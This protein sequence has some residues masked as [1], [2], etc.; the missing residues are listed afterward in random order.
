M[1]RRNNCI[2]WKLFISSEIDSNIN[3]LWNR[4]SIYTRGYDFW[5]SKV[6]GGGESR[7]AYACRLT[8]DPLKILFEI[9]EHVTQF[10][11]NPLLVRF[12]F[13]LI[14]VDQKW[15]FEQ[16][17]LVIINFEENFGW[18]KSESACI[19]FMWLPPSHTGPKVGPPRNIDWLFTRKFLTVHNQNGSSLKMG[20]LFRIGRSFCPGLIQD[21]LSFWYN[22]PW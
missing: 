9:N 10:V 14:K 3:A 20:V 1:K 18:I 13:E 22:F 21:Y 4:K 16:I 6:C 12:E 19:C 15:V 5:S 7:E 17:E 2:I 8:F 11:Q